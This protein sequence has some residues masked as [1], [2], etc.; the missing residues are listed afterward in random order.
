[1]RIVIFIDIHKMPSV[2]YA[3]DMNVFVTW[4]AF[5][6]VEPGKSY[7]NAQEQMKSPDCR[8][9]IPTKLNKKGLS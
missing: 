3:G 8:S 7:R 9:E 6:T 1:M 4:C 5:G 2:K